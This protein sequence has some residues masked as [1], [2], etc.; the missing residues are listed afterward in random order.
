LEG[1]TK[2]GAGC[3]SASWKKPVNEFDLQ[4]EVLAARF[5]LHSPPDLLT[6]LVAAD[7]LQPENNQ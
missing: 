1:Q 5:F 4:I 6:A 3:P 2:I 7:I